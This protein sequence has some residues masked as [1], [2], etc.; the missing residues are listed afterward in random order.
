MKTTSVSRPSPSPPVQTQSDEGALTPVRLRLFGLPSFWL[1]GSETPLAPT[2]PG[3]LLAYLAVSATWQS[4]D[5]VAQLFWP[6]RDSKAAYGNL[7]NLLTKAHAAFPFAEI[8]SS[9]HALRWIAPSDLSDFDTAVQLKDWQ[10]ATRMGADELLH[11]FDDAA[12]EPY[13]RWLQTVREARLEAW[14]RAVN[15]LLDESAGPLEAREA[16]AQRWAQRCPYDEDAV[17]AGMTLARERN[18]TARAAKIYQAF[19]ARLRSELGVKP[20]TELQGLMSQAASTHGTTSDSERAN[21][22][23]TP[24]A[25]PTPTAP[26]AVTATATGQSAPTP[27]RSAITGRRLELRQLTTLLKSD[28]PQLITLTGPGGVGKSTLLTTFHRQWIEA[29]GQGSFLIDVSAATDAKGVMTAIGA[30]LSISL[31]ADTPAEETLADALSGGTWVLLLDGAEQSGLATPLTQ[32]L[33]RCPQTR[34][35]IASRQRLNLDDEHLLLLEGFPLPDADETDP[36]LLAANDGVQFL[37][38]AIGKAGH[39]VKLAREAVTLA[40]IVRAV[41]GLPLALKLLSKLTHLYSP[42]QLLE[43]VQ[44]APQPGELSTQTLGLTDLLPALLVS[45][46]RSWTALS[47]NEQHALARL[48]VFPADFEIAAARKVARTEMPVITSLVDRSLVRADGAGRVSLHAAIRACVRSIQ[49]QAAVDVETDYIAYYTERLKALAGQAKSQTVRPLHQFLATD[50]AH[51]DHAW[52]LALRHHDYPAL[53]AQQESLWCWDNG[54]GL[55]MNVIARCIHAEQVLRADVTVPSAL[56]AM[57]LASIAVN[58]TASGQYA[59]AA[60]HASRALLEAR[61]SRHLESAG[62]A[63]ETLFSVAAFQRNFKEAERLLARQEAL[64]QRPEVAATLFR[65]S[66]CRARLSGRRGDLEARLGHFERCVFYA[67]EMENFE[68]WM[69]SLFNAATTCHAMGRHDQA[70]GFEEQ[71]MAMMAESRTGGAIAALG[72]ATLAHWHIYRRNIDRARRYVVQARALAV[73]HPQS[74]FVRVSLR[75]SEADL[76]TSESQLA[77]AREELGGILEVVRD[78]ELPYLANPALLI[79]G[80]WFRAA[81]H[82]EACA[83]ALRQVRLVSVY[84]R[85]RDEAHAILRELGEQPDL[86]PPAI[87]G[88]HFREAAARALEAMRRAVV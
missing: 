5:D 23:V 9:K 8:E 26:D 21:A 27:T 42:Q 69:I 3:Q 22:R 28:T 34:W 59:D 52:A 58:L 16:L 84:P 25:T 37:A 72:L 44:Q 75:L 31:T 77:A 73:G 87:V 86:N 45:F 29:G 10:S 71:V 60:E 7:R 46:Q 68:S 2:R 56:R 70:I 49:P 48:A 20:S 67:R 1:A 80:K 54:G 18:D 11:G 17:H 53:L 13:L 74:P 35:V 36:E 82:R 61:S 57:L 79:S 81:G 39:P 85:D 41:E 65:L 14:A 83:D 30:A 55:A 47:S 24:T 50:K 64:L 62:A 4:R 43:I 88:A 12:S 19:E 15:A 78:D 32:L 33:T 40:A 38:D 51:V 66:N 6:D 76:L 63:Q